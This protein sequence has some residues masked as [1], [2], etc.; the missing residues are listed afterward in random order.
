MPVTIIVTR[1]PFDAT[2]KGLLRKL[3]DSPEFSLF[4][5]MVASRC[6]DKQ[7]SAMNAALYPESETASEVAAKDIGVARDLNAVLDILDDLEKQEEEWW[8][9]KIE[10]RR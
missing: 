3:F 4:K 2:Q 7:V 9:V 6:T 10:P 5:E 8:T 1:Q